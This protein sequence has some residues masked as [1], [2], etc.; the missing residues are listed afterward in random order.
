MAGEAL[1]TVIGNVGK[2]GEVKQTKAG[3][4][5]VTFPLANTPRNKV[6]GSDE[7]ADSETTWY[8][9]TLWNRSEAPKKGDRLIVVGKLSQ[10]SY[11][12]SEGK[13]RVSLEIKAEEIGV[14]PR[15]TK[16]E[17]TA[18]DDFPW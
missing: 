4:D 17:E 13:P 8:R 1:I 12:D 9:V 2:D 10:H 7:W 3:K 6:V 14:V 18:S 5:Y 15:F 11:E 16:Q